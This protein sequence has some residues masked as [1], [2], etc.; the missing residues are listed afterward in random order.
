[1]VARLPES[2]RWLISQGR[3]QDAEKI[4]AKIESGGSGATELPAAVPPV[5][6]PPARGRWSEV[7]S[8]AY[9]RRTTIVW[10][11]WACAYFVSNGLN[12]WMPSLYSTVYHP[13]LQPALP[14]A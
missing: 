6:Q 10:A 11:L 1:M 12:N 13:P 2:P 7:L 4:I 9:R 8:R 5:A 14:P 3:L